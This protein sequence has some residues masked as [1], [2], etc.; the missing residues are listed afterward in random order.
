MVCYIQFRDRDIFL[1]RGVKLH[2][3]I[4]I[5]LIGMP[6]CNATNELEGAEGVETEAPVLADDL[7]VM[8]GNSLCDGFGVTLLL[9]TVGVQEEHGLSIRQVLLGELQ[10]GLMELGVV[11][12]GGEAHHVVAGQVSG[13][14]LG[15]INGGHIML[16]GDGID[17][18]FGVAV[19][20]GIVDDCSFHKI[21]PCIFMVRKLY[22]V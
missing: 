19:V 2:S 7:C 21:T 11:D 6:L 9:S 16:R 3:A 4:Q 10:N 18:L 13:L 8:L 14:D 12:T 5:G 20:L 22:Y 15:G 1:Q 17:Q